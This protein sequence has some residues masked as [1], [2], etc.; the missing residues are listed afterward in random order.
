MKKLYKIIF[1]FV[2]CFSL[3]S[4]FFQPS[5][6]DKVLDYDIDSLTTNFIIVKQDTTHLPNGAVYSYSILKDS[7]ARVFYVLEN[8][9]NY[10]QDT[11]CLHLAIGDTVHLFIYTVD[12]AEFY[13]QAKEGELK[14]GPCGY[15]GGLFIVQEDSYCLEVFKTD[16]LCDHKFLISK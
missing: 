10:K 2:L 12:P 3:E 1:A 13:P 6:S 11:L 7:I 15:L 9:C 16:Q 5:T 14:R 4:C 8:G